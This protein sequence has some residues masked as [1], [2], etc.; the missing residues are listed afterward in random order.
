MDVELVELEP[1][2]I[3]FHGT[4]EKFSASIMV[5]GLLK[6]SRLYVH[7]SSDAATAEKVGRRHGVPKIFVVE[8]R[9]MFGDGFKFFRSVNGVWLTEHVPPKFLREM[10]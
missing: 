3:L 10:F 4:A 7:L 5:Q 8:S 9:R 1:P 2:E 6:M